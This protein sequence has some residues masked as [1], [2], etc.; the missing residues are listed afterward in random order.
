MGRYFH[1]PGA[2]HDNLKRAFMQD[3]T[4]LQDIEETLSCH[5]RGRLVG[6]GVCGSIAA[7][8]IHRVARQ[9]MRHGAKVQFFLT[10]A[11]STLVSE[12]ALA[13]CTGRPVITEISARCEHLE[14]FGKE[15]KADLFLIAPATANTVAKIA[16][17]LDD[18]VVTTSAVTALGG[19]FPILC[20]PGM[21]EPMMENPAVR[22]NL[23]SL[24]E[25]GIE[26]LAPTRAEGKQK[27]MGSEEIVAQVMR[28][29]GPGSL[30][31]RSVL[32]TGGPTREYID[33]A[34]CLTNPSSGLS[35]CLIA[36]EAYRRGA[37]VTLVYGPGKVEPA[38]WLRVE[39]TVTTD[40]MVEAVTS[41]IS[42]RQPDIIVGVAAVADFRPRTTESDKRA[43][44]KGGFSLELEPTPK[45]I[46]VARKL[47]PDALMVAFKAATVKTDEE[48]VQA[49]QPYLDG[50]RA[51]LVVANPVGGATFG[52]ESN[53][54]R[55]LVSSRR[56]SATSLGPASKAELSSLLWDR[57]C[58]ELR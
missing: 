17:G 20:A 8:E 52:F 53:E 22:R 35:A 23:E 26:L 15:G 49:A 48:L 43:T 25:L 16:L 3:W 41:A 46:D 40:E 1:E 56:T 18:N 33:P 58:T 19:R 13:W 55:Y 27:M 10:P 12:T 11:A 38:P 37:E 28:C 50:G 7:I 9:L 24:E 29:L 54:N 5:L 36:S 34:R 42:L 14:Y 21:H 45:V 47:A 39:R 57:I 2:I 31:G 30:K 44:S 32:I 4:H 51:D 6:I